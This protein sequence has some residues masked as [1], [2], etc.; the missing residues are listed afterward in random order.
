MTVVGAMTFSVF[1]E[2]LDCVLDPLW[3]YLVP[4]KGDDYAFEK[5]IE[6]AKRNFTGLIYFS[7]STY[8]GYITIKDSKWLPDFLGGQNPEASITN[9]FIALFPETP[10]GT[11]C[12]ILF[13]YGYHV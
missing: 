9:S 6:K 12:Y 8:W 4:N 7:L 2:F 13:T 3:R 1:R 5:K 11:H 10:P